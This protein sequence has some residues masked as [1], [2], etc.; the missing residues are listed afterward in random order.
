MLE[1]G[2]GVPLKVPTFLVKFSQL[3]KPLKHFFEEIIETLLGWGW[4]LD[5]L[6]FTWVFLAKSFWLEGSFI[7]TVTITAIGI[8]FF[9]SMGFMVACIK[10]GRAEDWI[11]IELAIVASEAVVFMPGMG[12]TF[13]LFVADGH[14]GFLLLEGNHIEQVN[15]LGIVVEYMLVDRLDVGGQ[16]EFMRR[17]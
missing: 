7:S 8:D 10:A 6:G 13:D 16:W 2:V 4:Y 17:R 15:G 12:C 11:R 9:K 3:E 5:V 1:E 14:F